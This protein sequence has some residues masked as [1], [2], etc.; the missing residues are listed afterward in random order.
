MKGRLMDPRLGRFLTP[1]P[2]VSKPSF[3]QSWNPF[4]YVRNNPLK[5]VDPS[6][7]QEQPVSNPNL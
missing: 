6:G 5:Y 4:A 2:I 1:D 7:F 3:G